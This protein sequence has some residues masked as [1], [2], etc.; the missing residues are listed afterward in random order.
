[1][2]EKLL[3]AVKDQ[4]RQANKLS[5]EEMRE[6]ADE[7]EAELEAVRMMADEVESNNDDDT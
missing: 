7:V 1:M 2:K 6:L 4:L 3:K 5:P